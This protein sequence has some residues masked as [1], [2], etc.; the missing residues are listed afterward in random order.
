MTAARLRDSEVNDAVQDER[1]RGLRVF[2]G[3]VVAVSM[4]ILLGMSSWAI[5]AIL[6]GEKERRDMEQRSRDRDA[7]LKARVQVIEATR[8]TYQQAQADDKAAEAKRVKEA[9]A[10]MGVLKDLAVQGAR[11]ESAISERGA[12]LDRMEDDLKEVKQALGK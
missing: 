1:W 11:I 9:A 7:E 5:L 8:Y 4:P 3:I 2:G 12:R 6:D 10:F